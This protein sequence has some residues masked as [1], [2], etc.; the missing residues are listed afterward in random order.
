MS[1]MRERRQRK[2][3]KRSRRRSLLWPRK[4][5]EV[6]RAA[7]LD[8][9]STCSCPAALP[10]EAHLLFHTSCTAPT[11]AHA[12]TH[13]HTH[14]AVRREASVSREPHSIITQPHLDAVVRGKLRKDEY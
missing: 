12:D 5:D 10:Y 3:R 7:R 13:T 11:N 6:L 4:H 2:L 14:G 9:G 1:K 8:I